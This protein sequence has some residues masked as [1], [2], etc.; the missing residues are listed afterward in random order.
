MFP[1]Q[2][3]RKGTPYSHQLKQKGDKAKLDLT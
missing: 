1:S 3:G 2:G